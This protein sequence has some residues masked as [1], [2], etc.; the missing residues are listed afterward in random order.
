MKDA[1]HMTVMSTLC[2][3]DIDMMQAAAVHT[4]MKH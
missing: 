2:R 1:L 3:A 4:V